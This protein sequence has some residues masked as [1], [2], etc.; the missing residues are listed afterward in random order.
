MPFG[1]KFLHA[2]ERDEH[3]NGALE[4]KQWLQST[5]MSLKMAI[6][7]GE[8]M[9]RWRRVMMGG[10]ERVVWVVLMSVGVVRVNVL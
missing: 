8:S 6:L 9:P 10:R 1:D 5:L 4:S 3:I 7:N 2:S